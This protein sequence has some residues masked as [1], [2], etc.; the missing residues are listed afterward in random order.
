[1]SRMIYVNLP[2]QD[3]AA[4]TAF[5]EALGFIK[6]PHMC[7]DDASAL[8]WSDTISIML[9]RHEVFSQFSPKEI[10]DVRTTTT[11]L[12]SLS[13][14][15]RR[16]VDALAE[17]AVKHGGR[18]DVGGVHDDGFMYGR[19]FEDPDGNGFGIFWVNPDQP[20]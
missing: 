13:V 18:A 9:L 20:E 16:I 6:N 15:S 17:T 10:G 8:T 5:Y 12:I 3:L 7:N 1:M 2:V 19:D 4:T 14:E 11:A